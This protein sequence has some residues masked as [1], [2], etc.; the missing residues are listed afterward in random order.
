M[1]EAQA[2]FVASA[3]AAMRARAATAVEVT[4]DAMSRYLQDLRQ[5]LQRTVWAG[6]CASYFHNATGEIVTQVPH[7]ASWYR[8]ATQAIRAEDFTFGALAC[9]IS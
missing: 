8:E 1:L 9:T 6:G 3:M 5:N 7:T 2:Q 4:G